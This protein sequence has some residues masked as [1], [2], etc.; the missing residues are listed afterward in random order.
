MAQSPLNTAYQPMMYSNSSTLGDLVPPSDYTLS[1]NSMMF[2]LNGSAR[3]GIN[4]YNGPS[5]SPAGSRH[6]HLKLGMDGF[7]YSFPFNLSNNV[8]RINPSNGTFTTLT[9]PAL[10]QTFGQSAVAPNGDIIGIP[11]SA[12]QVCA[13]RPST[14]TFTNFGTDFGVG[15]NKWRTG[16]LA[17]NG[18]IYCSPLTNASI[19][20]IDP[21]AR[22]TRTLGN[23]GTATLKWKDGVL[24]PNGL[25]YFFPNGTSV[26]SILV[27]N[28]RDET[29]R[30]IPILN[31]YP[32]QTGGNSSI[33]AA[34]LGFDDK[35]YLSFFNYAVWGIFD[36]FNETIEFVIN[37]GNSFG[38][39]VQ[40]F[41][42]LGGAFFTAAQSMQLTTDGKFIVPQASV[43]VAASNRLNSFPFELDVKTRK[44]NRISATNDI[45]PT[46]TQD[47]TGSAN[48]SCMDRDGN[49]WTIGNGQQFIMKISGFP[50]ATPEMVTMPTDLSTL[51]SSLYNK[52]HNKY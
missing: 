20:V 26:T 3:Y 49:I 34:S 38:A 2:G 9:A 10:N 16:V 17:P 40:E 14:N 5:P 52:F 8:I 27:L 12:R 37:N 21:V 22:T 30:L 36:P 13:Y 4:I 28:P 35:I 18:L 50:L 6:I 24:H 41:G 43:A 29:T 32:F 11:S 19:L 25:I 42:L 44:I 1:H 46:W 15:I 31:K 23:F 51:P 45:I 33:G 48:G 47:G 39:P 7:I